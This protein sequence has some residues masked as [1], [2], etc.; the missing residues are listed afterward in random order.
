MEKP[1]N[2]LK[3][4]N[5]N[6]LLLEHLRFAVNLC[7]WGQKTTFQTNIFKKGNKKKMWQ[8]NRFD[9]LKFLKLVNRINQ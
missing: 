4:T 9:E 5:I 3:R 2:A 7:S 8:V 6:G 1:V